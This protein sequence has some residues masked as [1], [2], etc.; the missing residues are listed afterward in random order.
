MDGTA[1]RVEFKEGHVT[2][3]GLQIIKCPPGKH[4]L[5]TFFAPSDMMGEITVDDQQ[6]A[7]MLWEQCLI[8]PIGTRIIYNGISP[9][10]EKRKAVYTNNRGIYE[11]LETICEKP[12]FEPI[13]FSSDNSTMAFECLF[14]YDLQNMTDPIIMAFANMCHV[15]E[16]ESKHV[17]A[18]INALSQYLRKYMNEIYLAGNKKLQVNLQDIKT[19]LRAIVVCKHIHPL[20][21][22]F[23]RVAH[24][25]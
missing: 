18:F 20:F 11:M 21:T 14:T 8:Y 16:I 9:M 1:G 12:L 10:G 6:V 2:S 13:Y 25:L 23:F 19:G 17:V 4:G 7:R 22:G 3:K 5:K 15:S 24:L